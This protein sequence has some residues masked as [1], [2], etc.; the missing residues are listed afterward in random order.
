MRCTETIAEAQR[1]APNYQRIIQN[2]YPNRL[3]LAVDCNIDYYLLCAQELS[4]NDLDALPIVLETSLATVWFMIS[5]IDRGLVTEWYLSDT[6]KEQKALKPGLVPTRFWM[7]ESSSYVR[8][9][10]EQYTR[11]GFRAKDWNSP[12]TVFPC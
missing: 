3:S 2:C 10:V 9:R 7:D 1:I 5:L 11:A 4:C 12:H 8:N 6:W